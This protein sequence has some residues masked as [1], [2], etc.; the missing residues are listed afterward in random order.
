MKIKVDFFRNNMQLSVDLLKNNKELEADFGEIYRASSN[1]SDLP[2][3]DG[4][5][6]VIPKTSEQVL[7]TAQKVMLE[8]IVV[9]EVPYYETSN[10]AGG[11]TVYIASTL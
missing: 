8:N 11:N 7:Q 1:G 6:I 10:T 9:K 5:Y 2:N 3:Y 4:D